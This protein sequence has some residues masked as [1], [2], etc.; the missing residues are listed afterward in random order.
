MTGG[1]LWERVR[2]SVTAWLYALILAQDALWK[3]WEFQKAP[4]KPFVPKGLRTRS[5]DAV[6]SRYQG[7]TPHRAFQS[8]SPC[9]I[10]VL[11]EPSQDMRHSWTGAGIE[12]Q[13]GLRRA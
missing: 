2:G 3:V 10:H 13:R 12:D 6:V 5:D 8:C 11:L 9:Q 1:C 7:L 4:W